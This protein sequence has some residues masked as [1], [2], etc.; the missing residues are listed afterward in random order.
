MKEVCSES[1]GRVMRPCCGPSCR[2]GVKRHSVN[3]IKAHGCGEGT[4]VCSE[5]MMALG[6]SQRAK[7]SRDTGLLS[8]CVKEIDFKLRGQ[9]EMY[10]STV[11]SVLKL[12]GLTCLKLPLS[13]WSRCREGSVERMRK[14][15]LWGQ[16]KGPGPVTMTMDNQE[17]GSSQRAELPVCATLLPRRVC[18]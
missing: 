10:K 9:G 11:Q 3:T 5:L 4:W 18:I 17:S 2:F 14:A 1:E 15:L 7:V 13:L 12:R 6:Y 16:P 8:T